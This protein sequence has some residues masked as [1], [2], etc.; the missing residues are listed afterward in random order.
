MFTKKIVDFNSRKR[1]SGN[2]V[3]M[4]LLTLV[5]I[6]GFGALAVDYGVL[7]LDKAHL[8][9][10]CDAASLAAAQELKKTG[11]DATDTE[12]ATTVAIAT[13]RENGVTITSSDVVF[14]NNNSRITVSANLTRGLFFARI[15]GIVNG[16]T[17]ASATAGVGGTNS[18]YSPY[19]SPVGIVMEDYDSYNYEDHPY[20]SKNPSQYL[21]TFD[22]SRHNK[23]NLATGGFVLFDLRDSNGKS[24]HHMQEQLLGNEIAETTIYDGVSC[25]DTSC[26]TSLNANGDTSQAK[27]FF[28]GIK[29]LMDRAADGEWEDDGGDSCYGTGSTSCY[30]Q[31]RLGQRDYSNPRV[32]NIIVTNAASANNG[33]SNLPILKYV[34]VYIESYEY[35]KGNGKNKQSITLLTVRFLPTS[36]ESKLTTSLEERSLKLLN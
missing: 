18:T 4:L 2:I 3:V 13:A 23:E 29:T 36:D 34:P 8:Q 22:L 5:P 28:D 33:T 26:A 17:A 12:N 25:T 15:M 35:Q 7:V 16:N 27:K 6:M 20:D 10:A 14:S 11:N 9:C 31:M 32:I 1:K 30:D 21:R 19:V 24:T